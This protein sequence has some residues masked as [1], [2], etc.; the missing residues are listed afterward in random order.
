MLK[1]T[2]RIKIYLRIFL[3]KITYV[4]NNG[5]IRFEFLFELEFPDVNPIHKKDYSNIKSIYRPVSI[6]PTASKVFETL[7]NKNFTSYINKNY[8]WTP[9]LRKKKLKKQKLKSKK[10]N[11]KKRKEIKKEK[12]ET[13]K[14]KNNKPIFGTFGSRFFP[15]TRTTI[16]SK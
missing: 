5:I 9:A 12:Q 15:L 2:P 1:T 6:L 3:N 4:Y 10:Q 11:K 14:Y 13:K 16:F 7:M 8:Q